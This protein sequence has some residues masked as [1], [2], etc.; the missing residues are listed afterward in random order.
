M[1][2]QIKGS[3]KGG[4]LDTTVQIETWR[5][6]LR[7]EEKIGL[8]ST[9]NNLEA[10]DARI[11]ELQK[12]LRGGVEEE[13]PPVRYALDLKAEADRREYCQKYKHDSFYHPH[14][15]MQGQRT[16]LNVLGN[17]VTSAQEVGHLPVIDWLNQGHQRKHNC[18]SFNDTGH[19]TG[20]N[21]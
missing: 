8:G 14:N 6:R 5:Q 3:K 18:R 10:L 4:D 1:A 16:K 19:I 11:A 12:Q 7:N 9:K 17:T 13:A 2:K 15:G 21:G 20:F